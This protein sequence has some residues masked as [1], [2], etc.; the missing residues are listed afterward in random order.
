M[1]SF[2]YFTAFFHSE[3]IVILGKVENRRSSLDPQESR[4]LSSVDKWLHGDR[5]P[6]NDTAD[7]TIACY[8]DVA[9]MK[10]RMPQG[11]TSYRIRIVVKELRDKL[12]NCIAILF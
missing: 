10:V 7:S 3:L 12:G 9:D 5:L 8:T 2:Q 1:I 11:C 6:I 4:K